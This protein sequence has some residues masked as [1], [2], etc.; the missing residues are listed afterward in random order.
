MITQSRRFIWVWWLVCPVLVLSLLLI[1]AFLHEPAPRTRY[2]KI[3]GTAVN[4]NEGAS[5]PDRSV[6][7]THPR[8]G[9]MDRTTSQPGSIHAFE[10]VQLHVGVSG[11]L[12]TL[13]VDIGDI[14]KK[15]EVLAQVDVP[16]LELLVT[17]GKK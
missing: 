15:G 12:K 9:E 17:V 8:N 11:Y 10:S 16:E 6:Q 7:V 13:N 4:A 1:G 14:V 2:V 5:N 3:G